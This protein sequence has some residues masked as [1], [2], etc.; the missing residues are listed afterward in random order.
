MTTAACQPVESMDD[1]FSKSGPMPPVYDD[2]R[3]FP[4]FFYRSCAEVIIHPMGPGPAQPARLFVLTKD[5][6]RSGVSIIHAAQLF[7]G[8]RVE[9]ILDGKSPIAAV[10]SWC[11]R[12]PDQYF[13]IGCRFTAGDTPKDAN[14]S[15]P[16]SET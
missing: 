10:V 4:R 13:A 1:F 9:V 15:R 3:Q 7:P 2:V 6:S 5:L 12:L 14:V 16:T 8:Q 11:R